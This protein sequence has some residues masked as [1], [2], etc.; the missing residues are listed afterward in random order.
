M[1]TRFRFAIFL[2][3]LIAGFA[4]AENTIK[5]DQGKPGTQGPWPVTLPGTTIL[6]VKVTGVDGGSSLVTQPLQCGTGS[7]HATT[8]LS[9]SS[10]AMTTSLV[11][12]AYTVVCVSVETSGTPTV[13]CRADG[14][15]VTN[16]AG[17]A[18]D[19]LTTGDCLV[20]TTPGNGG[21][22]PIR[23]IASAAAYVTTYQ[24]VP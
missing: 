4:L 2:L 5:A 17:S 9:T 23:C 3:M 16:V 8:A 19:T 12:R 24:C 14:V 22:D 15:A 1:N 11:T 10:T 7:V 13:R 21:T 6:T 18:G 20:Y